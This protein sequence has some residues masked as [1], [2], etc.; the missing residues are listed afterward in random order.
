MANSPVR[1]PGK[2]CGIKY[3][4]VHVSTE[5][6]LVTGALGC[7]GAWTVRRLVHEGVPVW[8]YDLPGEPRRLR[9]IMDEPA[10]AQ[11]HFVEGDIADQE[12]FER[13]VADNGVTHIVHLAALQIPFVRADP[14]Q[15]ARVNVVGT[16]IVFETAK[17]HAQQVQGLAYASS[18]AVYGP[19]DQ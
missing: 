6:F 9:L 18:I 16:A 1:A 11:V 17:R 7:I 4:G 2:F 5:R 8:T 3:H 13:A 10:L 15:G 12:R 14:V 19:P